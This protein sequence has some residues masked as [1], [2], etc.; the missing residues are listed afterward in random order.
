MFLINNYKQKSLTINNQT[1]QFNNNYFTTTKIINN[2]I[3]LLST[4]IQQ[5]QNT[6]Q[7]LIISYNF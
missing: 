6:Y 2:K 3:N 7:Q 1:T 5:L 4:H